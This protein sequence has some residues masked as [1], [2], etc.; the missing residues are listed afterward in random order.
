MAGVAE[1]SAAGAGAVVEAADRASVAS[2][3][4]KRVAA[5]KA[6]V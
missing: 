6:V 2:P 5:A 3:A 4:G 1:A